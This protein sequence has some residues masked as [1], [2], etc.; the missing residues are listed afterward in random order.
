MTIVSSM[1]G[2]DGGPV[3]N[4]HVIDDFSTAAGLSGGYTLANGSLSGESAAPYQDTTQYLAV[5]AGQAAT[6]AIS[7]AV[8][9]LSFYWGFDR[10][11]QHR[12]L[13][14][15]CHPGSVI[16]GLAGSRR[17]RRRQPG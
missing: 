11:L 5:R 9:S 14:Q 12:Q 15:R 6:L 1:N 3:G 4:Q 13:L 8:K 10:Q 16:H 17:P 7:P 2:P